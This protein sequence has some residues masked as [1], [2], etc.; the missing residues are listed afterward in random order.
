MPHDVVNQVPPRVELDEFAANTALAEGVARYDAGWAS[1]QLH[2][3]GRHVGTAAFHRDA[4]LP[5]TQP[6]QPHQSD[7]YGVRVDEVEYDE[8]YHRIMRAHIAEGGHTAAFAEP[9]PGAAVARAAVFM[10]FAQVEPG[11]CCPVSMTH[12][13]VPVLR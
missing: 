4:E 1:E 5:N 11:H 9:R 6:P 13:A 7:R 2:R 8:S 12:S 10:L 3:V